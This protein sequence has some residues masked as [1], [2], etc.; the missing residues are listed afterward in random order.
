MGPNLRYPTVML[1]VILVKSLHYVKYMHQAVGVRPARHEPHC[2]FANAHA[3]ALASSN[4]RVLPKVV[5]SYTAYTQARRAQRTPRTTG[6][7]QASRA[8]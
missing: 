3:D 7:M 4:A 5:M 1:L 8:R 6:L 2:E